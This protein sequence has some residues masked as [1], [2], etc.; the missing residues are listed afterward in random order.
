MTPKYPLKI[1]FKLVQIARRAF[2][3]RGFEFQR[4]KTGRGDAVQP[5]EFQNDVL[6]LHERTQTW[7]I[8]FR[9]NNTQAY[10]LCLC[11]PK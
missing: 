9:H 2:L 11:A 8:S 6:H 10:M 1:N 5:H 3:H 4:Y 7:K